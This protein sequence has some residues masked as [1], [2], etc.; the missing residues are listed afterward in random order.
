MVGGGVGGVAN[1]AERFE[2]HA[3]TDTEPKLDTPFV[4][5][6]IDILHADTRANV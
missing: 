5:K 1:S 4:V 3:C 2:R 6:L